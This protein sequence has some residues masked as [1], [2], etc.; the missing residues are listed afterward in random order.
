MVFKKGL[1]MKRGSTLFLR[2]AV[3]ALAAVAVLICALTLPVLWS[4]DIASDP[5]YGG[6]AY[7]FYVILAAFYGA[8]VPFFYALYQAF[9]LLNLI[10]KNQ[11]FSMLSVEAL[12][13]IAFCAGVVSA[14]FAVSLPFFYIWAQRDDAPG[15]V[16]IG[17]IATGVPMVIGV[18]AAVLQRLFSDAVKIKS[19]NDLTV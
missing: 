9:K 3:L 5:E 15:L 2:L 19:E 12:K 4:G 17:M 18:F 8:M 11:A 10:D 16:I 6:I 14:L 7:V 13:R 1:R